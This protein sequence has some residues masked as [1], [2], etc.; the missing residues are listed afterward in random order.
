MRCTYLLL[1][2]FLFSCKDTTLP[3]IG[4]REIRNGETQFAYTPNFSYKNQFNITIDSNYLSNKVHIANFFFTSCP[5]ICPKTMKSMVR[6]ANHFGSREDLA[7]ICFSIDY[8]KDS[9]PRLLDYYGKL[10]IE[11]PNFHLLSLPSKEEMKRIPERY[12]SIAMEDESASGGFDHSGWLLLVDKNK[13]IRS[14]CLGTDE[15][16]VSRFLKDIENLLDD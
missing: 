6:I 1:A 13:N 7:Y 9:V 4:F 11:N 5:T 15:N 8:K 12:M 10:N 14:Y 2:L 3:I 16:E